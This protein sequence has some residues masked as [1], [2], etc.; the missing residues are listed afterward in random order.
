MYGH[1]RKLFDFMLKLLTYLI[2]RPFWWLILL[3]L[4]Y[5]WG[6]ELA[7]PSGRGR[8]PSKWWSRDV[9]A[10]P[11]F[12]DF[13]ATHPWS[14]VDTKQFFPHPLC[15][16]FNSSLDIHLIV[17]NY[18]LNTYFMKDTKPGTVGA[19]DQQDPSSALWSLNS[20]LGTDTNI[21]ICRIPGNR[22][23]LKSHTRG[24]F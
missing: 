7:E 10:F 8:Q 3:S 2:L 16:I 11:G 23:F 5:K 14:I 17:S 13:T 22:L 20:S 4:L 18:Y 9:L 21:P 12:I 6:N 24:M 19:R 1:S 15:N